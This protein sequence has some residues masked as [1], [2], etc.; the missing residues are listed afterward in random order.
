MKRIFITLHLRGQLRLRT[1]RYSAALLERSNNY[2][3]YMSATPPT[4][5]SSRC[6]RSD[7]LTPP[8]P[9]LPPKRHRFYLQTSPIP[10]I[11]CACS[12]YTPEKSTLRLIS[13]M[14]VG[15]QITGGIFTENEA[16]FGGFL[17][18]Q[19]EGKTSCNGSSVERHSGVDG[20]A[21]YAVDGAV[22][23]WACHLKDN[24]AFMGPAM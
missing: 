14:C 11:R 1:K 5:S 15:F 13:G 3:T 19:G 10:P 6:G 22:L 8:S 24:K 4:L 23:D 9:P 17:Y 16:D 20:G 2:V 12:F 18:A 7:C 21:I